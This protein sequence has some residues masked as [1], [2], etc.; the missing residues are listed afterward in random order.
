[1]WCHWYYLPWVAWPEHRVFIKFR[2]FLSTSLRQLDG[3][4][5]RI[6]LK[7]YEAYLRVETD[8]SVRAPKPYALHTDNIFESLSA[9]AT[10]VIHLQFHGRTMASI[11][12]RQ[13]WH[14]LCTTGHRC[15]PCIKP[16]PDVHK[17]QLAQACLNPRDEFWDWRLN[18]LRFY[19]DF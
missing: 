19:L 7:S 6:N 15:K 11:S 10:F 13:V 9:K 12:Y 18:L 3:V 2:L 14:S 17:T 5:W 8:T 1:M 16:R 4:D